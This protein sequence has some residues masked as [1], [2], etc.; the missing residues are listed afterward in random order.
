METI[1]PKLRI[2]SLIALSL[3]LSLAVT[4]AV[5][6]DSLGEPGRSAGGSNPMKN[7]YLGEQYLHTTN[8]P[9]AFVVGTRAQGAVLRVRLLLPRRP[10]DLPGAAAR[11]GQ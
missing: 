5:W 4:Q 2:K 7:V 3:S 6:A 10:V 11:D 1:A 8:S 9:D